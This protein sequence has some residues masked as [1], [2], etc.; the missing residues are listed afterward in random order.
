VIS[1]KGVI[2]KQL[3]KD[4]F[5]EWYKYFH[6]KYSTTNS[7]MLALKM[8]KRLL[9]YAYG[10]IKKVEEQYEKEKAKEVSLARKREVSL[11]LNLA[12]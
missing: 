10:Y 7:L 8:F 5:I 3:G 2:W 6:S 1:L 12:T 9:D 11:L 4:A